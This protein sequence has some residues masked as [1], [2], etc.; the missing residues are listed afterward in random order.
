MLSAVSAREDRAVPAVC[1]WAAAH[2]LGCGLRRQSVAALLAECASR[3]TCRAF[4]EKIPFQIPFERNHANQRRPVLSPQGQTGC[5]IVHTGPAFAQLRQRGT[6]Q[7]RVNALQLFPHR[8]LQGEDLT[9]PLPGVL[10]VDRMGF[11]FDKY[12]A[13]RCPTDGRAICIHPARLAAVGGTRLLEAALR[14]AHHDLDACRDKRRDDIGVAQR[15]AGEQS[16]IA[17]DAARTAQ[18]SSGATCIGRF[19]DRR[20]RFMVDRQVRCSVSFQ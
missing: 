19:G 15:Y 5:R 17:A 7:I 11:K 9:Y 20:R 4:P 12:L 1:R 3:I 16:A 2:L 8:L 14:A 6:G 18:R 13:A 10:P